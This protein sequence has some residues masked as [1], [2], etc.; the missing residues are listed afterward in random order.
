MLFTEE[1]IELFLRA[2]ADDG[3]DDGA[4]RRSR[5]HAREQMFPIQRARDADVKR[6][7]R[8][9]SAHH[10]RRAPK[11]M[12]RL[13]QKHQLFL[14]R[15][16]FVLSDAKQLTFQLR[17]VLA[18]RPRHRRRLGVRFRKPH[19]TIALQRPQIPQN[20]SPEQEH[21]LFHVPTRALRLQLPQLFID[22][23]DVVRPRPASPRRAPRRRSTSR[24]RSRFLLRVLALEFQRRVFERVVR[25]RVSHSR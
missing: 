23:L 18:H 6:P 8:P 5:E 14:N 10:Q 7:E 20:I 12:P 21:H 22:Q 24:L 4:D 16:R 2:T 19:L 11:T 15:H 3:G 13:L 25:R 9:S 1:L 17:H